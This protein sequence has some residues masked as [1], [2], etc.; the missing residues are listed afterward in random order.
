MQA[1]QTGLDHLFGSAHLEDGHEVPAL[2]LAEARDHGAGAVPPQPADYDQ[3][4]VTGVVRGV[5]RRR[6]AAGD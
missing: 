3:P 4:L 6:W 2:Q 5:Y 1:D